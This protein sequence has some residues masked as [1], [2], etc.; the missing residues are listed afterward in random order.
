MMMC[1]HIPDGAVLAGVSV[2]CER[3]SGDQDN[4]MVSVVARSPNSK[5]THIPL[6]HS[7]ALYL[8]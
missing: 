5:H 7:L 4:V 8:Q 3:E 6:S 1:G 2:P